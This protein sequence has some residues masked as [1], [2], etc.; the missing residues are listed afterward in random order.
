MWTYSIKVRTSMSL[1]VFH[2]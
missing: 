2:W 1:D